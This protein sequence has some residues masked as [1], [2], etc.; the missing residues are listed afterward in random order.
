MNEYGKT[1][2]LMEILQELVHYF[3]STSLDKV[4]LK[5]TNIPKSS[6]GAFSMAFQAKQRIIL[7]GDIENSKMPVS[8]VYL[9]GGTVELESV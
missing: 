2:N 1:K 4:E 5:I 8:K 7:S 3:N 9:N 6:L